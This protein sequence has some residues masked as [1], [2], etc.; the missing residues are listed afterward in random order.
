MDQSSSFLVN[1]VIWAESR[2]SAA[3]IATK[4]SGGQEHN[5]TWSGNH[6][7]ADIKAYIRYA[8]GS[9]NASPV[10][11]TDILVVYLSGSTSTYLENAKEYINLRKGIP[12]KF[13]TSEEDLSQFAINNDSV[14]INFSEISSEE[15]IN[16][17]VKSVKN[18]DSTLRTAF[19]NLDLN[20]NGFITADELVKASVS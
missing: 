14:F 16:K 1:V 9:I 4:L 10:G 13:V 19:N 12:F 15:N 2:D 5:D 11:V 18:L 8:N 7:G 20:Q 6:Q 3:D 17:L